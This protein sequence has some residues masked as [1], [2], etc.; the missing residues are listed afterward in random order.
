MKTFI[1]LLFVVSCLKPRADICQ[2]DSSLCDNDN[3]N[4]D[5]EPEFP[6]INSTLYPPSV[7]GTTP[8]ST[9]PDGEDTDTGDGDTDP[10]GDGTDTGDGTGTNVGVITINQ[11]H[12]DTKLT[13]ITVD[14]KCTAAGCMLQESGKKF[15][16]LCEM[17]ISGCSSNFKPEIKTASGSKGI[18]ATSLCAS[19][20]L[21][22]ADLKSGSNQLDCEFDNDVLWNLNPKRRY[23]TITKDILANKYICVR[24]S[25]QSNDLH[26][27]VS[28]GVCQQAQAALQLEFKW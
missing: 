25:R 18:A 10:D 21:T 8:V 27:A 26:L 28:Q 1:L 14:G 13:D 9:D 4:G 16:L 19:G 24:G 12:D 17:R 20:S 23:F 22:V 2:E 15:Q 3:G 7:P 6:Y 11:L 5:S